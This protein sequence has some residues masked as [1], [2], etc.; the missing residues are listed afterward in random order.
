[1][2]K[3]RECCVPRITQYPKLSIGIS[4][5]LIIQLK[6]DDYLCIISGQVWAEFSS[7]RIVDFMNLHPDP[8][9]KGVIRKYY[10]FALERGTCMPCRPDSSALVTA[11]AEAFGRKQAVRRQPKGHGIIK[12][13]NSTIYLHTGGGGR[14]PGWAQ[15]A[16]ILLRKRQHTKRGKNCSLHHLDPFQ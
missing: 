11:G 12:Q 6:A 8:I 5:P 10:S 4:V 2:D 15:S 16:L 14:N 3:N 7:Q 1:M 9:N 13:T